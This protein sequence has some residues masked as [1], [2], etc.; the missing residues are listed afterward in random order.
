MTHQEPKVFGQFSSSTTQRPTSIVPV[1]IMLDA[2]DDISGKE[3]E[4]D[5]E[6]GGITFRHAGVYLI[7]AAPQIGK[8]AGNKPN[9]ID[10]WLRINNFDVPNS[11]IRAVLRDH[12]LKTVTVTQTVTRFEKGD[13][14]D[15]MMA[16]EFAEEG[17]GIESI[18]PPDQP[19]IPSIML[20]ILQL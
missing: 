18:Q 19:H 6:K 9:W 10:F 12:L 1:K 3:L 15:I 17:L 2:Q 20:T 7:I 11:N 14:L 16:V 4:L 8:L 5:F 13:T